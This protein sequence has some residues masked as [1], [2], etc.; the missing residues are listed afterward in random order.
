MRLV[1]R[2]FKPSAGN[3]EWLSEAE[4]SSWSQ[5][6]IYLRRSCISIPPHSLSGCVVG[7]AA[8]ALL[9]DTAGYNGDEE[10]N[11]FLRTAHS[12]HADVS[13]PIRYR[14]RSSCGYL[15]RKVTAIFVCQTSGATATFE[16]KR[17]GIG[18]DL[19]SSGF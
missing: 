3:R 18:P 1:K 14:C 12:I 13:Y 16:E 15:P 6:W 7:V 19:S 17:P 10:G 5:A 8:Q 11:G 9:I 2:H 4:Q